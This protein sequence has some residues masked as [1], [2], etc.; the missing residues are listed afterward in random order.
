MILPT[1][2][3]IDKSSPIPAYHQIASD[4][5]ERIAKGEWTVGDRFPPETELVQEYEVSR[6]TMRQALAELEQRGIIE[7][8]RGR[9][10]F[11]TMNPTPFIES[12]NF[13]SPNQEKGRKNDSRILEW[14]YIK[15][16]PLY[17]QQMFQ[18]GQNQELIFLSRLF[19]RNNIPVGLNHTWFPAEMVPDLIEK[20][21]V[22]KSVTETLKARYQ[23]KIQKV[24]NYI[25]A[26]KMNAGEAALLENSYDAPALKIIST[27][28]LT[29]GTPI[30]YSTTLWV[31]ATT[32]FRMIAEAESV[33]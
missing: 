2:V 7:R 12:L 5:I 4:L 3:T 15:E 30:E 8:Q 26:V 1:G 9:G 19:M 14:K 18:V 6:V 33:E 28:C 32:R 25:E 24:E 16:T 21:L 17:V 22:N 20:G 13:P 11:L 27:H 31:A 29:D 23:Y 10:S